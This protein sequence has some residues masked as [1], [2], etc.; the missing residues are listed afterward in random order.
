[1]SDK[2]ETDSR[3]IPLKSEYP[4]SPSVAVLYLTFTSIFSAI[5]GTF[6]YFVIVRNNEKADSKIAILSEYDLGYLYL[7]PLILKLGQFVM[8]INLGSNRK[9]CKVGPPDQ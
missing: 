3:G 5:A 8:G 9:A 4:D 7:T 1:M 2:K 6:A